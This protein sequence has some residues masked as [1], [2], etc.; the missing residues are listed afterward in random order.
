MR[1]LLSSFP[2]KEIYCCR[3]YVCVRARGGARVKVLNMYRD[4][5]AKAYKKFME[6]SENEE[7]KPSKEDLRQAEKEYDQSKIIKRIT[8]K[9]KRNLFSVLFISL[10]FSWHYRQRLPYR[11]FYSLCYRRLSVTCARSR[12]DPYPFMPFHISK[13]YRTLPG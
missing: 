6:I 11:F 5:E 8:D 7:K 13:F 12:S 4:H 1:D 10:F 2:H 9:V 3:V